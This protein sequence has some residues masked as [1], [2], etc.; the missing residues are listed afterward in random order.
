VVS[1][2]N[3]CLINSNLHDKSISIKELN[4]CNIQPVR[5]SDV[6]IAIATSSIK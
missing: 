1:M 5:A 2:I 4:N 3:S 6:K